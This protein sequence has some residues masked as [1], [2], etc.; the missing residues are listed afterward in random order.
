MPHV[1]VI[2]ATGFVGG[3]LARHF[4]SRGW[5]V[6][7]LARTEASSAGLR[8]P[9]I[10]ALPGDLDDR[11]DDTL[12]AAAEADV[13]VYAAQVAP[14]REPELARRL[15]ATLTG[16]DR[17]LV[18]LSGTGVFMQR[19][20][21]AWS[22]DVVAE[23]D[24]F[25]PEPL[26]L[27]RVEAETIVRGAAPGLRTIVIRPP[28]IWGDGD[29]GPVA[30]TYRSV[31]RTGSACYVGEGLAANSNVSAVDLG[32][33][34]ELAIRKGKA[35]ALY[36]GVGGEIP[37]RWIAEAVARDLG[38]GTRS[39]TMQEA[40]EVFGPFGVLIMSASS[41]SRDPR[42]RAELGWRPTRTD[43]L[44]QIGEPRLRALAA[45]ITKPD[46]NQENTDEDA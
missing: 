39:L 38:V 28:T 3:S 26:A 6:T 24:A 4:V 31:G 17:T 41:R 13:V 9:G 8:E 33:L 2:G 42:T 32:E 27:P 44:S 23:D 11:L 46:I 15:V 20:G 19:T 34:L 18:F 16:T 14:D 7:G 37:F 10:V 21:G 12:A 43:M 29:D 35:G 40:T 22:P 30:Q 36:H 1:F 45:P 5:D 25:T